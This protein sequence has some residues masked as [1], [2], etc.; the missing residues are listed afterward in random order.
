MFLNDQIVEP[1]DLL[2]ISLFLRLDCAAAHHHHSQGS[3]SPTFGCSLCKQEYYL[4]IVSER[5]GCTISFSECGGI[6]IEE[7]WDKVKAIFLPTE[8]PMTTEAIAPLIATLPLELRFHLQSSFSRKFLKYFRRMI[9]HS[10]PPRSNKPSI[11]YRC[12]SLEGASFELSDFDDGNYAPTSSGNCKQ[13]CRKSKPKS[14]EMLS[15]A[16]LISAVDQIW[17]C[18]SRSLDFFQH[19]SNLRHSDGI[20]RKRMY[21]VIQV[22]KEMA[23]HLPHLRRSTFPS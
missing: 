10:Q 21:F 18:A 12:S 7:N 20:F 14:S 8:K 4:S 9:R 13:N 1:C 17:N 5:L 22:G 15:T 2:L 19:K 6:E 3:L 23:G 16:E 11:K